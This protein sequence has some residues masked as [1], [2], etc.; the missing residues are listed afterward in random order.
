MTRDLAMCALAAV[1]SVST[2]CAAAKTPSETYLDYHG[3]TLQAKGVEDLVAFMPQASRDKMA[4]APS[5]ARKSLF[6]MRQAME[7]IVVGQPKVVKEDVQGDNAT[8]D[9]EAVIDYARTNPNLGQKPAEAKIK[10]VK[11]KDGWKVVNA[12]NWAMK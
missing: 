6:E 9:V 2:A 12:P 11:E 7:K 4:T 1:I 5:E 8:L 3:A 10:L